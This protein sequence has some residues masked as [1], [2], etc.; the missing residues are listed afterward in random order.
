VTDPG[1]AP[2]E[3]VGVVGLG[4]IGGSVALRVRA[5]WPAAIVVGLDRPDC[6]AEAD[7]RGAIHERASALEDLRGCDLVVLAVPLSALLEIVPRLTVLDS[8]TIVTDVASTK[9]QVMAA[10]RASALPAFVGGHPMAGAERAGIAHARADL[11]VDR[12]W[13]LVDGTG[14]T[15]V[16]ARVEAFVLALGAWPRWI[17]AEMHDRCVAYVSHLPQL[18]AVALMNA[19]A[20]GVGAD[21]LR[22]AGPAFSDMTRL[23]S[24]PPALWQGI[25]PA[26]AD[27]IAEAL[28]RFMRDLPGGVDLARDG[29]V[30]EA[31]DRAGA[32][33]SRWRDDD[34]AGA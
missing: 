25:V 30:R 15:V 16:A 23:A 10:G 27:F 1:T 13:L 24:S 22:M 32:A 18:V 5:I 4:L 12:P 33:R 21:G 6:L 29:W 3:R 28:G 8:R 11:F 2:F 9:R 26:N 20:D 7:R 34:P 17:D 14:G 31:F 19:A